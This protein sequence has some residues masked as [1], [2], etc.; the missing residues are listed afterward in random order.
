MTDAPFQLFPALDTATEAAL[1]ESVLRFGVLVPVVRDQHGRTLDGHHRARVADSLG[2][3]FRVD[4]VTVA[5]DE[6]A[7]DISRTLNSD[8]RHMDAPQR[9]EV[10]SALREQGHSFRAIAGAL[11]VSHVT[12]QNDLRGGNELPPAAETLGRDGKR[13]PSRRPT[14]VAAKNEREADRAQVALAETEL[15]NVQVLDVKRVERLAREQA[16]DRRRALPTLPMTAED[17]TTILLGDFRE[18]LAEYDLSDSIVITDPPYP[19]EFLNDWQDMAQA[20]LDWGC[21]RLVSM[22]GQSILPDALDLIRRAFSPPIDEYVGEGSWVY[23]WCGAYLM[24]GPATRV[25]NAAVGSAWK[26]ILVFEHAYGADRSE[27]PFVTTDVFRS[28]GDDKQHHRWGQ[29]EDGIAALVEAFTSPGDL[30]VDPFLGGGTTA[31]VCRE[32]GRRFVGCDIDAAAV[33]ATRE[34]LAA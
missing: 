31:V 33:S 28:T 8:R 24:S 34:R 3:S 26:P 4:V 16:A 7:L 1:R 17:D 32:L 14:V 30:V 12:V 20:T 11:G 27:A 18:V 19:R 25:W 22:C 29:N 9:R 13:Y 21:S 23:R 10:E 6:E 5:D 2:V 15:P